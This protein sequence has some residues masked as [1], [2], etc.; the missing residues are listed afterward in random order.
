[1]DPEYPG[2]NVNNP[3]SGDDTTWGYI[4]PVSMNFN[5]G[6]NITF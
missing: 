2:W 4:Y 1:M 6:I 5:F 3:E